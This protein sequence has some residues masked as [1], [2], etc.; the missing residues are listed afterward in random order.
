MG[1][2]D[3]IMVP[4]PTCGTR[5][6]AQSKSGDCDLG[7]FN[8]EAASPSAVGD[9]NRHAPFICEKCGGRFEVRFIAT[10]VHV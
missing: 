6:E 7:V 5:A 2:Y 8:L 1:M 4:C 10:P 3:T 9:V